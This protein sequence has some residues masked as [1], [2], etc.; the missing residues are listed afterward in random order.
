MKKILVLFSLMLMITSVSA[1][2]KNKK[3]SFEVDGVCG[4]CK[5]RIEKAAIQTKG[6]KYASWDV[7]SHQLSLIMDER[8]CSEAQ[9]KESIVAVGHD[10]EGKLADDEVY[11]NLMTCCLYRSETIQEEHEQH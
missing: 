6:V 11:E 2:E 5:N 1:Q 7:K 8:K 3:V 4:M 10:V 9:V